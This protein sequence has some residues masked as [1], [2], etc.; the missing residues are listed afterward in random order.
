MAEREESRGEAG[1]VELAWLAAVSVALLAFYLAPYVVRGYHFA[2]GADAPVYTWWARLAGQDGLSAVG[3]RPGVPA[4][5]LVGGGTL[6]LP[7][8]EAVAALGAALPVV[9][10]LAAA[11]LIAAGG[12]RP[13]R[14]AS[15]VLAGLFAGWYAA[16]LADGY[17]A[18]LAAG[19]LFLAALTALA[20]RRTWAGTL[21]LGAAGLCHPAFFVVSAAVLIGAVAWDAWSPHDRLGDG[22]PGRQSIGPYGRSVLGALAGAVAVA[23]AGLAATL[24][25]GPGRIAGADTSKDAFL[26]RAG[27]S[28]RL[29]SLYR[30]RLTDNWLRYLLPLHVPLA[31]PGSAAGDGAGGD[32]GGSSG[33]AWFLRRALLAWIAITAVGTVV[34][35]AT[36]LLPGERFLA[37]AFALPILSALGVVWLWVRG[38]GRARRPGTR[39]LQF[40]AVAAVAAVAVGSVFAWR[41]AAQFFRPEDMAAATRAARVVGALPPGTPVVVVVDERTNPGL[42]VPRWGNELRSAMPPDRIREL[43]VVVGT[44]RDFLAGRPTTTGNRLRDALSKRY[45]ADFRAAVPAATPGVAL[46]LEPMNVPGFGEAQRAGRRVAPGVVLLHRKSGRRIA[47]PHSLQPPVDPLLPA[48]VWRILLDAVGMLALLWAIG[49]GWARGLVGGGLAT[50][51]IAPAMGVAVAVVAGL[52]LDRVGVR[53]TGPVPVILSACVGGGGYAFAAVRPGRERGV[54]ER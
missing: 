7:A 32:D 3:Y 45:L 29:H 14:R 50:A 26:R 16:N 21:A 44:P 18:S 34:A 6:N 37:F 52:A 27:L 35:L 4:L 22:P 48:P 23:A 20:S 17:L 9:V 19:G 40:L 46:V 24:G 5:T 43:H 11:G 13:E 10:G 2:I 1:P 30:T 8:T 39:W 36:G 42:D 15:W 49:W 28:A 38:T 41:H 31:V 47:I 54:L 33:R 25:L 12:D 51:A 53:L